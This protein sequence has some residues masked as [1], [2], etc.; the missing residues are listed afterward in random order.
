M[1]PRHLTLPTVLLDADPSTAL[2]VQVLAAGDGD[3]VEPG[4]L[5]VA[6][7]LGQVWGGDVFDSS[8]DGS[9]AAFS[10]SRP[11][12]ATPSS[13]AGSSCSTRCPPGT[14]AAPAV[15]GRPALPRPS[16]S[17]AGATSTPS[18]GYRSGAVSSWNSP[19]PMRSCLLYTSDAA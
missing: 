7:Y 4:D 8:F 17:G 18:S 19:R 6:D 12:T 1:R 14:T 15:R 2:Q 13:R 10:I 16:T 5:L 3:V 11:P 9:P